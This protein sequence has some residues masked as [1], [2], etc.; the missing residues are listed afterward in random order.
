[1]E[2]TLDPKDLGWRLEDASLVPVMTD[3]EPAPDELLNI[4]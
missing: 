4:R 2:C 3:E 1:M